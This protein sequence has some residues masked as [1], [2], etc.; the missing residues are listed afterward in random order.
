M[1]LELHL[2]TEYSRGK[3]LSY[4]S[5]I[6][7]EKLYYTPKR[8]KLKRLAVAITDHDTTVGYHKFKDYMKTRNA[9]ILLIPGM[10]YSSKDG[11]IGILGIEE[12]LKP[13]LTFEEVRDTAKE[14]DWILIGF[15]PF[16]NLRRQG[17]REKVLN[18]DYI[19]V[20][21]HGV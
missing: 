18:T 17:I 5:D 15:H 21:M 4:E 9:P 16:D 2:H 10:E 11:H 8:L 13:N 7:P 3:I 20:L 14:N 1:L 6:T 19:E 12:D